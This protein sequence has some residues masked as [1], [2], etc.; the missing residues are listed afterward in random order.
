MTK[1]ALVTRDIDILS[2]MAKRNLAKVAHLGDD[3]RSQA[4]ADDEAARCDAL[5]AAG[6]PA[7]I[8]GRRYSDAR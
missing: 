2:R 5:A 1:S 7:A 8:L 6:S 4:G 3:T